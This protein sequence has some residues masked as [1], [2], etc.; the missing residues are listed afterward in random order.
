MRLL[1]S[2][3]GKLALI[4]VALMALFAFVALASPFLDLGPPGFVAPMLVAVMAAVILVGHVYSVIFLKR[5][6]MVLKGP[7]MSGGADWHARMA[8]G[9]PLRL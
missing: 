1:S 8:F 7:L 5:G 4:L 3:F 2:L 6:R 9:F